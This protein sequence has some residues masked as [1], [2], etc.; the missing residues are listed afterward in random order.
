MKREK[1]WII[2]IAIVV[3][4]LVLII[5]VSVTGNLASVSKMASKQVSLSVTSNPSSANLYVDGSYRG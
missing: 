1:L 3:A 5:A 4:V 2:V